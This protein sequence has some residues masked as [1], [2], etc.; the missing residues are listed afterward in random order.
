MN[1]LQFL[2]LQ[3]LHHLVVSGCDVHVKE[4]R[5]VVF[6]LLQRVPPVL[7]ELS[8][9]N[10]TKDGNPEESEGCEIQEKDDDHSAP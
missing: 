9:I 5:K 8:E 10:D 3:C 2:F 7:E 4:V 1:A 6:I